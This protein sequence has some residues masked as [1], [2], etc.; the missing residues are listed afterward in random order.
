MATYG[1][2]EVQDDDTFFPQMIEN[3]FPITGENAYEKHQELFNSCNLT[4]QRTAVDIGAHVGIWSKFLSPKFENVVAF[5]PSAS[6]CSF[7]EKNTSGLSNIT[8]HQ[9]GLHDRVLQEPLGDGIK[10]IV[11]DN[12]ILESGQRT[13]NI[14]QLVTGN[15]GSYKFVNS[16]DPNMVDTNPSGAMENDIAVSYLDNYDI[17]NVDLIQLHVKGNELPILIG[18]SSTINNHRPVIIY[19]AYADQVANHNYSLDQIADYFDAMD[20]E[21]E[22]HSSVFSSW[23]V[24]YKIARP[25]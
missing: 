15:H 19:Q 25:I 18:A 11:R 8:L 3:G 23:N 6:N 9:V 12:N 24:E 1:G 13:L 20:Y 22:D 16:D 14:R 2:W 21:I 17:A 10:T 4:Q 7:F 5:E